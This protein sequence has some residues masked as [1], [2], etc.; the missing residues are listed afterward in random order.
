[1]RR[2]LLDLTPDELA[3]LRTLVS[4]IQEGVTATGECDSDVDV[5]LEEWLESVA[6]RAAFESLS[7]KLDQIG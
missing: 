4:S 2:I 1:M 6:D 5:G 3:L 7:R